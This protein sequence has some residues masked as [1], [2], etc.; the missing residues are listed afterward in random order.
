MAATGLVSHEAL[1]ERNLRC[2][3][4]VLSLARLVGFKRY[5]GTDHSYHCSRGASATH[6]MSYLGDFTML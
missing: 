1:P 3:D 6:G 5:Q 2:R 4:G